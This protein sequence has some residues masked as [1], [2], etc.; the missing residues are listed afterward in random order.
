MW[1][2][3]L[4]GEEWAA[5]GQQAAW[6]VQWH[7]LLASDYRRLSQERAANHAASLPAS[8]S[9][10]S[11]SSQDEIMPDLSAAT[12]WIPSPEDEGLDAQ[13]EEGPASPS[14][15]NSGYVYAAPPSALP[16]PHLEA[17]PQVLEPLAS[18]IQAESAH[19]LPEQEPLA[20]EAALALEQPASDSPSPAS[21]IA[22][23][24]DEAAVASEQPAPPSPQPSSNIAV[25]ED[26]AAVASEQPAPPSPQSSSNIAVPQPVADEAAGE[27]PQPV[28]SPRVEPEAAEEFAAAAAEPLVSIISPPPARSYVGTCYAWAGCIVGAAEGALW[29]VRGCPGAGPLD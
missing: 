13:A 4:Y 1:Q 7:P 21:S 11:T 16:R 26:E 19:V 12:P 24:E 28:S 27:A 10:A 2:D 8:S 22:V 3:D 15:S 5:Q 6:P 20:D 25:P 29:L 14:P 23:P 17:P 9:A 18:G